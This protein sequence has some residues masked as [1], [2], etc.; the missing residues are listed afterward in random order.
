MYLP[1][2]LVYGVAGL[3]LVPVGIAGVVMP[4][5]PG[6]PILLVAAACFAL[7]TRS[8]VTEGSGLGTADRIKVE[9]LM[10]MRSVLARMERLTRR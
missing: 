6:I 10:G 5:L 9:L 3:A 2:R 7:A 4:L 1:R 8:S